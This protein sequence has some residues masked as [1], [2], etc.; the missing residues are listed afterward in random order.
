MCTVLE[1]GINIEFILCAGI[2]S[3]DNP[4][5]AEA[6]LETSFREITFNVYGNNPEKQIKE[7]EKTYT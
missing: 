2:Q 3:K 5:P 1:G 7:K 4:W 6:L